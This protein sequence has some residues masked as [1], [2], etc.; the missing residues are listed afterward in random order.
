MSEAR[1]LIES[2][3]NRL[4]EMQEDYDNMED[5]KS[6]DARMLNANIEELTGIIKEYEAFLNKFEH[7]KLDTEFAK[8]Q[9][10]A[11]MN[12]VVTRLRAFNEGYARGEEIISRTSQLEAEIDEMAQEDDNNS[13]EENENEEENIVENREENEE[14]NT[15]EITNEEAQPQQT[16]ETQSANDA[17]QLKGSD[18]E[19]KAIMNTRIKKLEEKIAKL[20]RKPDLTG[21]RAEAIRGF[22][23]EIEAL[24]AEA[25]NYQERT[26]LDPEIEQKL[27][28]MDAKHEENVARIKSYDDEIKEL[29]NRKDK[30]ELR[31]LYNKLLAANAD[32]KIKD[33]QL[34]DT[35]GHMM[36]PG[37]KDEMKVRT[38]AARAQGIISSNEDSLAINE[39][40]K[41]MLDPENSLVDRIQDRIY[42]IRGNHYRKRIEKGQER[43]RELQSG[44]V[45]IKLN[46]A[47]V[48]GMTREYLEGLRRQSTLQSQE[49]MQMAA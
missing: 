46:G 33:K 30:R 15:T 7:M 13:R 31:R 44:D 18:N 17:P 41:N 5:K 40:L 36:E 6:N 27:A 34:T 28:E 29:K 22:E 16:E 11:A 20:K 45:P 9:Y 3:K 14:E 12:D 35:E 10:D 38:K 32:L 21:R 8:K 19:Y 48:T 49:S 24:K 23:I 39:E 43:L 42:D 1:Y 26:R 37:Y 4:E 47:R 25:D 2:L